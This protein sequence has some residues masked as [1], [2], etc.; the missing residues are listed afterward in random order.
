M[1]GPILRR[2][3]GKARIDGKRMFNQSGSTEEPSPEALCAAVRVELEERAA[4][5]AQL[6]GQLADARAE[7]AARS[8]IQTR[9]EAAQDELR[10]AIEELRRLVE[11]EV[12]RRAQLESAA[13][14]AA[15]RVVELEAELAGARRDQEAELAAARGELEA[16]LAGA[17][18][19]LA[20]C[21][22]SRD[23]ANSEAQ[24]LRCELD[25]LGAE[26]AVAREESDRHGDLAEARA[27]LVE[28][29]E[30]NMRLR[31][32]GREPADRNGDQAHGPGTD[33]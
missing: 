32:A 14:E 4:G 2:A 27:M 22:V 12:A 29:H 19:D 6:R 7:L 33:A 21:I 28:A 31:A 1:I 20:A 18:R 9:L 17:R 11:H 26:L 13:E 25:R 3:S 8:A 10:D 16:E 5:E 24:G 23:A 15:A 30:L